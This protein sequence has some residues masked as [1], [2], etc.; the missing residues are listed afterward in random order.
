MMIVAAGVGPLVPSPVRK[1]AP[2]DRLDTYGA[3]HGE[4]RRLGCGAIGWG[5]T[6]GRGAASPEHVVGDRGGP[7]VLLS[8]QLRD[9][10]VEG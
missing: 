2:C 3:S 9:W 8:M 1:S 5:R 4:E 6:D 10:G 7:P